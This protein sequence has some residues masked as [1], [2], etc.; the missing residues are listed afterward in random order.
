MMRLKR[1]GT[2]LRNELA[3][4]IPYILNFF[5]NLNRESF[6]CLFLH[7]VENFLGGHYDFKVVK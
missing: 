6:E 1:Y 2:M 7:F 5:R 3:A 4:N